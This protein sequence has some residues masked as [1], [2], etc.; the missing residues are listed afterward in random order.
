MVALP[1]MSKPPGDSIYSYFST[2]KEAK[3]LPSHLSTALFHTTF[4]S[5]KMQVMV[6]DPWVRIKPSSHRKDTEL[7]SCRL[8]PNLFPFTGT[9]G[10][11]HSLCL[12]A[13]YMGKQRVSCYKESCLKV[14]ANLGIYVPK[15]ITNSLTNYSMIMS[16]IY[17]R[18]WCP[19]AISIY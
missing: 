19:I 18:Q 12:K 3:T 14:I 15:L 9:P 13:E 4:P 7:P 8:S 11:G 1:A 5:F 17:R 6:S 16:R 2:I 10:S